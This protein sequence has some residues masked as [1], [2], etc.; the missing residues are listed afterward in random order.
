MNKSTLAR[1][2]IIMGPQLSKFI[3][4]DFPV[5][6]KECEGAFPYTKSNELA[7][8]VSGLSSSDRISMNIYD[9]GRINGIP[10]QAVKKIVH[11]DHCLNANAP[12]TLIHALLDKPKATVV[13]DEVVK[14]AVVDKKEKM[15]GILSFAQDV[16]P[17]IQ[18]AN[19]YMLYK[20]YYSEKKA[21]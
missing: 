14:Q 16:V 12:V 20:Y 7:S 11:A 6:V 4:S 18:H 21:I 8:F 17:H 15:T 2:K 13:V 3:D 10:D 9:I 5:D 19:L 1:N